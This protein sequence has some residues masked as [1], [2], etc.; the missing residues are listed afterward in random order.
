MK[1][2]LKIL[3]HIFSFN[4]NVLLDKARK[5]HCP[6]TTTESKN[7]WPLTL[8]EELQHLSFLH[9]LQGGRWNDVTSLVTNI[10]PRSILV[11]IIFFGVL[12]SLWSLGSV[13]R[14]TQISQ[15]KGR[16]RY[17]LLGIKKYIMFNFFYSFS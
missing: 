14:N 7:P 12:V 1:N 3:I 8:W 10:S 2:S 17:S 4:T 6:S 11:N 5:F 13:K 15:G 16:Q 9:F